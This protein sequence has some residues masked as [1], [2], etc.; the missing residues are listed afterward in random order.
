[1]GLPGSSRSKRVSDSTSSSS[2][3]S[4]ASDTGPLPTADWP[5]QATDS[6]I[7]LVDTVRDK[8]TGPA[9]TAARVAVYG[10]VAAILAIPLVILLLIFAMRL[11]EAGLEQLGL[12]DPIWIVYLSF[13]GL[14]LGGGIW[15]WGQ[16][17][18][19]PQAQ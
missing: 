5:T 6:I 14:F 19:L 2:T 4:D 11:M 8:T 7:R 12:K 13:G 3:V 9:I 1:M 17:K 15:S 16:S 18:K 10:T